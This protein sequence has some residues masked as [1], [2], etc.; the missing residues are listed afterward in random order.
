[1][2]GRLVLV[3]LL[4]GPVGGFLLGRTTTEPAP[5]PVVPPQSTATAK[6]KD[7]QITTLR[8]YGWGLQGYGDMLLA[9]DDAR[10]GQ[11][12]RPLWGDDSRHFEELARDLR[13][14]AQFAEDT[15]LIDRTA[16]TVGEP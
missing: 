9:M 7:G 16:K 8:A 11:R 1:M 14:I 10:A 3:A 4:T 15:V 6:R 12:V 5:Q 2:R 13:T